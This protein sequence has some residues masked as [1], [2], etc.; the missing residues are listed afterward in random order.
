[1]AASGLSCGMWDLHCSMRDLSLRCAGFLSL[2]EA[3][4]LSSCGTRA[5]L[6]C[7]MWDVSSPTRDWTR[8]LCIGRRF[9]YHWTTREVP[10]IFFLNKLLDDCIFPWKTM[11]NVPDLL[12]S[13]LDVQQPCQC[14]V[15][16][17]PHQAGDLLDPFSIAALFYTVY[18]CGY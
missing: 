17:M 9:L 6:P 1:M 4:G 5:E 14:V 10:A 18:T 2:D 15:L 11:K 16:N 3:R 12:S 7:S 8:V 13:V